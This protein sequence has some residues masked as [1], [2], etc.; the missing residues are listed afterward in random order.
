MKMAADNI[1]LTWL[2]AAGF[3]LRYAGKELLLDPFLSRPAG[4]API[5]AFRAADFERVSL[6]LVSHGHFDHA[7]DVGEFGQKTAAKICAPEN[8]C[9]NLKQ[10]GIAPDRLYPSEKHSQLDCNGISIRVIPSQHMRFDLAIALKN[11]VGSVRAGFLLKLLRLWRKYPM[12]SISEF[13]MNFGGYRLLFSG[14]GGADWNKLAAFQPNCMMVPFADRS[15]LPE[16]YMR[17]VRILRPE[18]VVLHHFDNLFPGL[19][20]DYP[21]QEF[22]DRIRRESPQTRL[23]VP[24]PG[25]SFVLP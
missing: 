22:S 17:A 7:G 14:S 4:S 15:D 8:T 20:H 6:I 19:F 25:K 12:G 10:L 5:T 23:I 1:N 24:S 18:C 16:F 2:G 21:I 13:L 3:H 9:A 11:L